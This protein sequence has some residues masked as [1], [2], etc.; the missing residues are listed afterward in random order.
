MVLSIIEVYWSRDLVEDEDLNCSCL[1]ISLFEVFKC[2]LIITI[3]SKNL[4][5]L[6]TI[7]KPAF[8]N[9]IKRELYII[10]V[11]IRKC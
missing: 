11:F 1:K 7:K 8:G 5:L 4:F 6:I 2:L 3:S 9:P 10:T